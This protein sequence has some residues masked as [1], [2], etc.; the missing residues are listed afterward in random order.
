[1][2]KNSCSGSK[3]LHTE[4]FF[5]GKNQSLTMVEF[6]ALITGSLESL[7]GQ[8]GASMGVELSNYKNNSC[9]LVVKNQ[10]DFVKL[11]S[12]LTLCGSYEGRRCMFKT[13]EL[14]K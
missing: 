7:H 10:S 3:A 2:V 5:D 11:W 1:M 4:L 12:A 9:D 13:K 14:T 6:Q 8:V